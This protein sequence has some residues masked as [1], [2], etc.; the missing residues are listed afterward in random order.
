MLF[1]SGLELKILLLDIFS[2]GLSKLRLCGINRPLLAY[3]MPRA[4]HTH[5]HTRTL[6]MPSIRMCVLGRACQFELADYA[7]SGSQQILER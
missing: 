7:S 1:P 2:G 3:N 5:T 4:R 6:Q